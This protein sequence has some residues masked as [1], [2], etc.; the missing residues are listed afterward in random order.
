MKNEFIM[1]EMFKMI[2]ESER[3]S[4]TMVIKDIYD[5]GISLNDDMPCSLSKIISIEAQLD[6]Q[7]I[8][9]DMQE[10]VDKPRLT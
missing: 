3:L 4:E 1:Q 10:E 2:E 6:E 8:V 7:L 5:R 9:F